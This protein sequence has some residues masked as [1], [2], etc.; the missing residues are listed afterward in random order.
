MT[1]FKKT[2][3]ASGMA[4]ALAGVS[5]P[6]QAIIE[7]AAG[8]ALLVPFVLFDIPTSINTL[9]EV[10]VPSAVGTDTVPNF[11]TAPNTTPTNSPLVNET[12]DPDLGDIGAYTAGIHVYFFDAQSNELFN[13]ELPTSPDDFLLINWGDLV[14]RY[15]PTLAGTPGYMV[16]TNHKGAGKWNDAASFSMFGDAYMV[17]PLVFGFIDA[18]IPVLPMSDGAD[19]LAG[20]TPPSV[21]NNVV[22]NPNGSIAAASPLASGMRTNTSDGVLNDY[23]LFDTTISNRF[24]PTLHVIWVDENIGQANTGFVFNDEEESCSDLLP[25]PWELNL[26]W[27]SPHWQ[28]DLAPE[29][30]NQVPI[31]LC[32][33]DGIIDIGDPINSDILYP[34]FVRW[35]ISEYIDTGI[36]QPESAAVAFSIHLQVDVI[37]E[38]KDDVVL[39][40]QILP[41]ETAL[42][43]ERAQFK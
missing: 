28:L 9:V 36:N 29:W 1:N 25:I 34:G 17:F 24:A 42:A 35:Q 32:Y 13:K 14:A 6:S 43:H 40:P 23:T 20:A 8:E 38:Q 41:V 2:M 15:K 16:I 37:N 3:L 27:T 12:P 7:G 5:L 18:K 4:A 39:V 30:V 22:F 19:L 21:Q 10:T 31:E 33:P 26:Y 11:F